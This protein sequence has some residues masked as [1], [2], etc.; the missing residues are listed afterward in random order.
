MKI[1]RRKEDC[2]KQSPLPLRRDDDTTTTKLKET[3]HQ[4]N[5]I[6]ISNDKVVASST[7]NNSTWSLEKPF[8]RW[9]FGRDRLREFI[10][11][12]ITNFHCSSCILKHWSNVAL[13]HRGIQL[14]TKSAHPRVILTNETRKTKRPSKERKVVWVVLK[15]EIPEFYAWK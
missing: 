13:C 7:A 15:G 1:N 2:A 4:Q 5:L 14:R 6:V 8:K 3:R 9:N 12:T 10:N 11:L